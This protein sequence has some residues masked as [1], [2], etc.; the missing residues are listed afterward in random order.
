MCRVILVYL[1]YGFLGLCAFTIERKIK[2]IVASA[3][4]RFL[5]RSGSDLDLD[6]FQDWQFVRS[7]VL[8]KGIG[9]GLGILVEPYRS[10]DSPTISALHRRQSTDPGVRRP[11]AA[12]SRRQGR[13]ENPRRRRDPGRSFA[14]TLRTSYPRWV[15]FLHATF[16]ITE[17]YVMMCIRSFKAEN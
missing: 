1:R 11:T 15:Q 5:K 2:F 17:W 3:F 6:I 4:Y 10:V 14:F 9:P 7:C 16:V 8:Q 12:G 13:C